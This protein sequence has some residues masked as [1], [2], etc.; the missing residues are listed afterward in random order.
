MKLFTQAILAALLIAG[1]AA[2][3]SST[4]PDGQ[5]LDGYTGDPDMLGMWRE[6][7]SQDRYYF[8]YDSDTRQASIH[9]IEYF[10]VCYSVQQSML[11]SL[12]MTSFQYEIN[13]ETN[14]LTYAILNSN[15]ITFTEPDGGGGYTW[16]RS[17][18]TLDSLTP[19]C[20]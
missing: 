16:D 17:S 18:E 2:C 13:G 9:E 5:D 15:R 19:L 8:S 10:D 12:S 20:D 7:G 3:D 14:G 11:T 1:L 6:P 4:G